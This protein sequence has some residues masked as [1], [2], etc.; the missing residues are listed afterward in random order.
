[1]AGNRYL[2]VLDAGT[3]GARCFV[4]DDKG[5]IVGCRARKWDYA[6]EEDVS[7]LARAFD[8]AS[9]GH[10]L[11]ELISG[12]LVDAQIPPA[13]VEAVSVTSQRQGV[14]FL[15]K[16]VQEIYAGPNTDLRAVFEGAAIDE[17]MRDRVYRTTGHLPSFLLAPAKLRWFQLHRPDAYGRIASVVTLADWVVWRLTGA[18]ASEPT[19]AGEAGLLDV[20][21]RDWCTALLDDMGLVSGSVPLV[22]AG[23]MAGAVTAEAYRKTGLPEGTPV[24][25]SGADTQ[26]GL[27][28]MGVTQEH[29][30]GIVAGWSAPLQMVTRRPVLSPNAKTWAGCFLDADR[31]VLESSA[32]DVG[33]SYRWLADTLFGGGEDAFSQMDKLAGAVPVGSEGAVA[34]LGPSRM[35]MTD[36]GMKPG[37]FLFPVPLTFSDLSRANLVRASLEATAYTIKANLQQIEEL[38]GVQASEIM[39]GGG[40]THTATWVK[41]LTDVIGRELKV[42]PTPQVTALGAY[43]CA[44]TALGKFGSLDEAASSV[45]PGLRS[46]EPDPLHSAEYQESYERWLHLAGEIQGL[47]L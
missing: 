18:L 24:A 7:S 47:S 5:Q 29:Q 15:D 11:C 45:R 37:G 22:E 31:W 34:F 43:L 25:V 36:L 30:V 12:T 17:E 28:G 38:A 33:N 44:R 8:P 42:S 10:S 13:R 27:L 9:L 21:R 23:T 19:L 41:I 16:T 6:V 14:V 35:D 40:M 4:F 26:C 20:H 2:L 1:M 32:G 46:M 3:S 39:V